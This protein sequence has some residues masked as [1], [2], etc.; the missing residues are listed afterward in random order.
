MALSFVLHQRRST[1]EARSGLDH[2]HLALL[3]SG[4]SDFAFLWRLTKV[5]WA[6]RS[7]IPTSIFKSLPLLMFTLAHLIFF[8]AASLLTS[9]LAVTNGDVLLVASNCGWP[10]LVS[11]LSE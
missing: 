3:R 6:W 7:I 9:K 1:S 5:A 10:A 8:V 4:L 2:Q 11:T